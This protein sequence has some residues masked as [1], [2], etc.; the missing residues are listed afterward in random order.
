M[1]IE[2]N[3]LD[4][5]IAKDMEYQYDRKV[6]ILM[7]GKYKNY[8][9]Y[10]LNLGTHPTA[11]VEIPRGSK[12]F[13]KDYNEIIYDIDVHG[14]LTYADDHLQDIKKDSWFL[15]WDYAH[16]FDYCGIYEKEFQH[17]NDG[18][19][20]WTTLEI[21]DHVTKVINQIIEIEWEYENEQ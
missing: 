15:G 5:T 1:K 10:I 3:V 21:F 13:G 16:A 12:L 17:I 19:K 2:N 14:G 8:Q 9:F 7:E 18:C 11:Y 6:E 20:K 4:S